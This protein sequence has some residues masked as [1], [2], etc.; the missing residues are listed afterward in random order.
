[1]RARIGKHNHQE[2]ASIHEIETQFIGVS[3]HET[4]YGFYL[5]V[6]GAF[7]AQYFILKMVI[8]QDQ[9][10]VEVVLHE[11]DRG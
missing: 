8:E 2:H 3:A 10:W 5:A 11:C 4:V 7:S 6:S 9:V 1:M